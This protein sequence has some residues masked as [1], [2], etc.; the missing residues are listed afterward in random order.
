VF[1][2]TVAHHDRPLLEALAS[3]L[4]RGRVR[5]DAP[6]GT[7]TRTVT[8]DISSRDA[9]H[10]ATVPFADRFLLPSAKRRQFESWRAHLLDYE[11][12]HP[13]RYGRGPSTCRREG[14][15]RPVRGRGLC[16]PHYYEETGY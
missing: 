6:R 3:F 14:C 16:R 8:F 9:H 7:W 2:V 5:K 1:S 11:R 13:S 12:L 15:T 10:S 4:G